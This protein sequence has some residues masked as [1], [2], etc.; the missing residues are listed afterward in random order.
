MGL[1]QGKQLQYSYPQ[2]LNT[3]GGIKHETRNI[4]SLIC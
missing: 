4:P 3:D 1:A 2:H